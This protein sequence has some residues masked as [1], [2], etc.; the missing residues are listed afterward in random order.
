MSNSAAS[1]AELRRLKRSINE[2]QVDDAHNRLRRIAADIELQQRL[3]ANKRVENVFDR[4]DDTGFGSR[5]KNTLDDIYERY[6]GA[7][8]DD[9]V[10]DKPQQTKKKVKAAGVFDE[11]R[12]IIEDEVASAAH[13]DKRVRSNFAEPPPVRVEPPKPAFM[14]FEA[15]TAASNEPMQQPNHLS[16]DNFMRAMLREDL[17]T[18]SAKMRAGRVYE[19]WEYPMLSDARRTECKGDRRCRMLRSALEYIDKATTE[20]SKPQKLM[21]LALE[22]ISYSSYYG[23][24]LQSNLVRLLRMRGF[25]ELR[26]DCIILAP[27]RFG[28]TEGLSRFVAA[29]IVTQPGDSTSE[30]GHDVLTYANN[31]RASKMM[32]MNSYKYVKLLAAN[33]EFGGYVRSLNKNESM[34]FMTREGYINIMYAYPAKP[35]TLRGTG[36]R[37][38]TGTVI[39]EEFAYM[40]LSIVFKI[41]APTLTRKNVKFVGITTVSGSDSFVTP[42]VDAKYPDGRSVMLT[43]NFELICKACKDAGKAKQC[44]CLMGDI[45]HWQSQ[46]NHSK[47]E[48]LMQ[49][50][51][52]TFMKELRGMNLEEDITPAFNPYYVEYLR[53][54]ESVMRVKELYADRVYTAVDPAAGGRQS[55]VAI[56]SGIIRDGKFIVSHFCLSSLSLSSSSFC[57]CWR[58]GGLVRCASNKSSMSVTPKKTNVCTRST[59]SDASIS[60][61]RK[62]GANLSSMLRK[63][64]S[65]SLEK[66]ACSGSRRRCRRRHTSARSE[67]ER[68][69]K[70]R[71]RACATT[72]SIGSF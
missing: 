8:E 39:A 47:L 69:R 22:I 67:R 60:K 49:G 57:C 19:K 55:K 1:G 20:R 58:G 15:K 4:T 72:R 35:E 51:M 14:N 21:C 12:V 44:K 11:E 70:Q 5:R 17:Q 52:S 65:L 54:P 53:T 33:P 38:V 46:E 13:K 16:M 32:L 62:S 9:D 68:Q 37:A 6:G 64:S 29:E 28:K 59:K 42:L 30:Y 10:D 45:P 7:G 61:L 36:S 24:E 63:R 41:I 25:S 50:H 3:E 71:N 43:L 31:Q 34:E 48:R 56:V 40:D 2:A 27:R 26:S 66:G 18:A 23:E